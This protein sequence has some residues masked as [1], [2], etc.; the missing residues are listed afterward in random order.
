MTNQCL[1]ALWSFLAWSLLT[2]STAAFAITS[3][4]PMPNFVTPGPAQGSSK[5]W[6]GFLAREITSALMGRLQKHSVTCS[7]HS[8]AQISRT[9]SPRCRVHMSRQRPVKTKPGLRRCKMHYRMCSRCQHVVHSFR[10]SSHGLIARYRQ[11]RAAK[12]EHGAARR[13]L[14]LD[15][16]YRLEDRREPRKIDLTRQALNLH[17][18]DKQFEFSNHV[19]HSIQ[20]FLV[21][22]D[23]IFTLNQD[24][25]I[26]VHYNNQN[27]ALWHGTRWQGYEL[28]GLREL[29]ME[30]PLA[31]RVR[32]KWVPQDHF[33]Q[34]SDMQPYFKLRGSTAWSAADNSALMVMGRDKVGLIR[35]NA[36]LKWNYEKFEEYPCATRHPA[37]GDW[38]W[39][40]RR[41]HQRDNH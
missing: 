32:S 33:A 17:L 41:P 28:P 9:C 5:N 36:I 16:R 39:L 35:S 18:A 24:L 8:I 25:L 30:D 11:G 10:R 7:K 29:P 13:Q 27:V 3:I 1:S 15:A 23:A 6:G 38:L 37:D 14:T 20:K 4:K 31:G 22:F 26:E 21:R 19:T 34:T 2:C 12:S 40:C